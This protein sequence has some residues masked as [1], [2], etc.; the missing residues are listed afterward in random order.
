MI[1]DGIC[2]YGTLNICNI[3]QY[4]IIFLHTNQLISVSV[5][6]ANADIGGGGANKEVSMI[7]QGEI[8]NRHNPCVSLPIYLSSSRSLCFLL[9]LCFIYVLLVSLSSHCKFV[10]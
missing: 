3:L 2:A 8:N 7:M 9:S 10:A 1:T 5:C 6:A 4:H